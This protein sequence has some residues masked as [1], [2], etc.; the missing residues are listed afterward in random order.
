MKLYAAIAT[1]VAAAV[2]SAQE[3]PKFEA[4]NKNTPAQFEF[5]QFNISTPLLCPKEEVCV[6]GRGNLSA[7]IVEYSELMFTGKY[8]GRVVYLERRNLCELMA[9]QGHPCPVL[10][11]LA[12]FNACFKLRDRVWPTVM[13]LEIKAEN[14]DG[15]LLFCQMTPRILQ[16][17]FYEKCKNASLRS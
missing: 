15:G 3:T 7:P 11:S 13:S 1:L 12:S 17:K 14:G 5:D 16:E 6:T 9:A 4:C 10:T 8:L 2:A